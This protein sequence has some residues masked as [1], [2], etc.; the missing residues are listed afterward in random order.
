MELVKTFTSDLTTKPDWLGIYTDQTG[1]TENVDFGFDSDGMW[2]AGDASGT[3]YTI[4][5]NWSIQSHQVSEVIYTVDYNSN[6]SDQG[7]CFYSDGN[8]PQWNWGEDGSRIAF[9]INC[10]VPYIYG[11]NKRVDNSGETGGEGGEGT[12]LLSAPNYYT[13]KITYNPVAR[14]VTAV[15][16]LGQNTSGTVVDTLVL[17]EKLE[18]GLYRIGFDA[19]NDDDGQE[20]AH[21]KNL[22]INIYE[23]NGISDDSDLLDALNNLK[24]NYTQ[25]TDLVPDKFY[26]SDEADL[27]EGTDPNYDQIPLGQAVCIQPDGKVLVGGWSGL[28]DG[29][30]K[31][32][33]RFNVDGTEDETFSAP[34][35]TYGDPY[36]GYGYGYSIV[37]SIAV[38]SDGKIVVA[39]GFDTV[40]RLDEILET[41][42]LVFLNSDGS[43]R[44]TFGGLDNDALVVKAL[45]D[46][47]VLVGGYFNNRLAKINSD[48]TVDS[49]FET[50]IN[51]VSLNSTVHAID[52][53]SDGK[54]LIGG[55]FSNKIKRLNADG[56]EDSGFDVGTGFGNG[57][58]NHPRVSS[59]KVQS[60][61]KIVVGHWFT[62][63][64]GN[65]VG[66][67]VTR[68]NSD[69]TLDN[70]F[71][72]DVTSDGPN[73]QCVAIQSDG[74][75]VVGG[76]FD[77][78]NGDYESRIARLNTDGTTDTTFVTGFGFT[79]SGWNWGPRVQNLAIDSSGNIYC[80]GSFTDYDHAAR[81]QYAKL[82]STGALLEWSVPTAFGQWGIDDGMSDMY[83]GANFLNTNLTQIYEDVVTNDQIGWLSIPSTHTQPSNED[84]EYDFTDDGGYCEDYNYKPV[85]D[86]RI[87]MGD[88]YFGVGSSYFTAMFHGM[89]VLCANNINISEFS[90]GGNI[91]SDGHGVDV[92]EIYPLTVGGNQ[93]TAFVKTN[94]DSGSSDP[95]INQIIIVDGSPDELEQLYDNTARYDD[96][97]V[98]NLEGRTKLYYLVVARCP[99]ADSGANA[100]SMSDAE[101]VARK[102][103]EIA[104]NAVSVCSGTF[105]LELSPDNPD[106]NPNYRFDGEGNLD[107]AIVVDPITG[108]RRSIQRTGYITTQCPNQS[109]VISVKDGESFTGTP[110][111]PT[112]VSN[113][114]GNPL[115]D[116]NPTGYN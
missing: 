62:T 6:C 116:G 66:S 108:K 36:N 58:G 92:A 10:P 49:T 39:G 46:D 63:Y 14:T 37:R 97:C 25:I 19:D 60:N 78:A 99:D 90:V 75:I 91:G 27:D 33:R 45:S 2:F 70:T 115:V 9:S 84:E 77:Y 8:S 42:G 12:P 1:K 72:P 85:C 32:L 17:H 51:S 107:T 3:A 38:L 71:N 103:L 52:V 47:S 110:E 7:I 69:A 53:D 79:P 87:M 34:I 5:T 18:G 21:F 74:K 22:T 50:N 59:I 113:P 81:Y 88:G 83:D 80:A 89:F 31:S 4:R 48:E 73:V 23:S 105:E 111:V 41:Q 61:G 54:I 76:W 20:H 57:T 35:F 11:L 112:I 65:N 43:I 13:F 15:T 98:K 101:A 64:N 29:G 104:T 44:D 86:S 30:S 102:F 100:L 67:G 16:Y 68:L 109:R 93:Y 82:S 24:E 28:N 114:T 95:S 55:Q 56:T 26:F 40:T 94:T 106:T 96:H